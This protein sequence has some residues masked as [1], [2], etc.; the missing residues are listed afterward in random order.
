MSPGVLVFVTII[1]LAVEIIIVPSILQESRVA[2][3]LLPRFVAFV[4]VTVVPVITIVTVVPVITVVVVVLVGSGGI[5]FVIERGFLQLLLI[6]VVGVL[7]VVVL[8]IVV[9]ILGV[10][11]IVDGGAGRELAGAMTVQAI[12]LLGILD[13]ARLLLLL[14]LL[15]FVGKLR[16]L[17]HIV[18]V[19]G[20]GDLAKELALSGMNLLQRAGEE[21]KEEKERKVLE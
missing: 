6:G 5:A 3:A 9:G 12:A 18:V 13:E 2:H 10:G 8:I 16:L 21:D 19:V 14:S 4:V 11:N 7:V 15:L 20:I 1:I 17:L